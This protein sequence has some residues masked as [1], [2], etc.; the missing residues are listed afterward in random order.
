M[1]PA[2][3]ELLLKV[4]A[5]PDEDEPRLVYADVLQERGDERGE[6]IPLQCALARF[7]ARV[8]PARFTAMRGR[9]G[10]LLSEHGPAWIEQAVPFRCVGFFHRGF[11]EELQC[12]PGEL[13]HRG[14]E[15]VAPIRVLRLDG[16][17]SAEVAQRVMALPLGARIHELTL[18][19]VDSAVDGSLRSVG[20]A[21]TAV[22]QLSAEANTLELLNQL[23][24]LTRLERLELPLT[25]QAAALLEDVASFKPHR[26]KQLWLQ[27]QGDNLGLDVMTAIARVWA[28][29]PALTIRWRSVDYQ[30]ADAAALAI[31]LDPDRVPAA[32]QLNPHVPDPP[33]DGPPSPAMELAPLARPPP[34]ADPWDRWIAREGL[35]ARGFLARALPKGVTVLR[36]VDRGAPVL[37]ALGPARGLGSISFAQ[38][39]ARLMSLPR[40][41]DL[42]RVTR[43]AMLEQSRWALFESFEG[44]S[45]WELLLQQ[46][47][48]APGVVLRVLGQTARAASRIDGWVPSA[49]D[50]LL[51]VLGRVRLLPG[52]PG[53]VQAEEPSYTGREERHPL[54]APLEDGLAPGARV[55]QLG[56]AL[57]EL[58][59]GTKLF[60]VGGRSMVVLAAQWYQLIRQLERGG[61]S[62]AAVD[63]ALAPFEPLLSRAMSHAHSERYDGLAGFA[64][65]L[66]AHPAAASAE[67]VAREVRRALVGLRRTRDGR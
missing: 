2:E 17:T 50:V 52:F 40:S 14:L 47:R 66:E 7:S 34:S 13:L 26:L 39:V 64:D 21:L 42:L 10:E 27:R 19:L 1:L 33:D 5:A 48:L 35:V 36:A 53:S 8:D 41:P 43:T 6:F 60:D 46:P 55:V 38:D 61:L 57:F 24:W 29:L 59:T 15:V 3:F 16:D 11:V 44:V 9:E 58:L 22:R 62:L 56:T 4:I 12:L 28:E 37:V 32:P 54:G 20:R 51:D 30:A 23:G 31:A 18:R 49:D 63:P 67:E 45:L 25:D 65:A